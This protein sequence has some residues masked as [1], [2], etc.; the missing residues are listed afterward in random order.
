M[1]SALRLPA[2]K[3]R[4]VHGI[5]ERRRNDRPF[6]ELGYIGVTWNLNGVETDT[7]KEKRITSRS[8]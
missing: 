5:G 8:V 7:A 4:I 6:P 1:I 3:P 2:M